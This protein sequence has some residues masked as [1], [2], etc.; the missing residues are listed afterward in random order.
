METKFLNKIHQGD[1]LEWLKQI[2]DNA[3]DMTFADPPFNLKKEYN[4]YKDSLNLQEYLEWCELWI[5]EMVRITK[6][7]GSI[8]VHNIP[9]WLTYFAGILNKIADFKHWIAWDAPT[10]PMGKTLQPNHYGILFY[11]KNAKQLKFYEVRYP[12]KRDRKTTYLSKD[13]GGK[14]AG[15]HPFGSLVSDIWTDIHR[16]KH[17][18][19]RDQHPCQLPVHL[20]ERLILMTTDENDIVLD[21]FCGTGTTAIAAKRLGRQFIGFELDDKYATIAQSKVNQEKANSKLGNIWVSFYLENVVTIRDCD[22][23]QLKEF[24]FIP[25]KIEDIDHTPIVL[26]SKVTISNPIRNEF[27]KNQEKLQLF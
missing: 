20:L 12:H 15:L 13:Y 24:F 22:W 5:T 9:K 11:A 16:V 18:K 4:S 21:P 23:E 8:F 19:Y 1:C 27:L 25:T 26:K 10:A 2:P 3:V 6:P 17:N 7:T 14:K